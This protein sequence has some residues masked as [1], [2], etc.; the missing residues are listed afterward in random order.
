MKLSS[1]VL[2]VLECCTVEGNTLLLPAGQ[3]DRKLYEAV[4]KCLVAMGGKW[5]RKARG[6]V[7]AESPALTL[8]AALST[9]EQIDPRKQFQFFETPPVVARHMVELAE[10]GAMDLILEPSAGRGA[11]AQFLGMCDLIELYEPNVRYLCE[12]GYT[13]SHGDFL[14]WQ[15]GRYNRIV[16]NPPFSRNQDIAHVRHAYKMLAPGG[17]IVAIM[18]EHPFFAKDPDSVA[19]CEWFGKGYNEKL[20]S[21]T[22]ST[23]GVNSRLVVINKE[24]A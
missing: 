20:P 21:G 10:I 9:G 1:E 19:F 5:D 22:F 8:E 7:F 15:C 6:H 23:T 3:L 16:M 11:I 24:R 17:R 13:V 4:N 14:N 2:G 18:S 12:V